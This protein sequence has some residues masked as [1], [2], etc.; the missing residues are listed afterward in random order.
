[1]EVP[2]WLV[3]M[4]EVLSY[5]LSF[6]WSLP[7][8]VVLILAEFIIGRAGRGSVVTSF[9][10]IAGPLWAPLGFIGVFCAFLI[11]TYYSNVGGWCLTYLFGIRHGKSRIY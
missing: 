8:G 11:M 4:E 6:L 5:F 7:W 2:I 3:Q 10:R 9:K 1:M